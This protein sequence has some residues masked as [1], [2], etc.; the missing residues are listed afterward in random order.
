MLKKKTLNDK[1]I[2]F[3]S[4]MNFSVG[5]IVKSE[6]NRGGKNNIIVRKYLQ[7]ITELSRNRPAMCQHAEN[8]LNTSSELKKTLPKPLKLTSGFLFELREHNEHSD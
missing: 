4:Q 8:V 1:K 7:T 3:C 6:A 5:K 2:R